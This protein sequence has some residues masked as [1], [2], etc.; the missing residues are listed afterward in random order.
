MLV[1][2]SHGH[3]M[4]VIGFHILISWVKIGIWDGMVDEDVWAV[5][6]LG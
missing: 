3:V 6:T 2:P 1:G 5:S 4:P